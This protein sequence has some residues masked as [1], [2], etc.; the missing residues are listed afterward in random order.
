MLHR[1]LSTLTLSTT[2]RRTLSTARKRPRVSNLGEPTNYRSSLPETQ[3]ELL[4][5]THS[6]EAAL[7]SISRK[8]YFGFYAVGTKGDDDPENKAQ[9]KAIQVRSRISRMAEHL[10]IPLYWISRQELNNMLPSGASGSSGGLALDCAPFD[11]TTIRQVGTSKQVDELC[12]QS[13]MT[14]NNVSIFLDEMNDPQNLGATL[15]CACFLGAATVVVSAKNSAPFSPSVSR[16]SSGALEVLVSQGRLA[17]TRGP[18]PTL[19]KQMQRDDWN[20]VGTVVDDVKSI[21]L[22]D[23]RRRKN[24]EEK[25]AVVMGSEGRGM[26]T[27]VKRACTTLVTL[28]SAPGSG[29]CNSLNVSVTAGLVMHHYL[30][31]PV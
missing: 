1:L 29:T 17:V 19:L 4:Y 6:V 3:G 8:K 5:G 27:M 10:N 2:A 11:D 12:A 20:I 9:E 13:P 31:E 14:T 25:V 30:R 26:R 7:S 22:E 23:A 21:R 28:P 24:E 18:L 15:R 16:A